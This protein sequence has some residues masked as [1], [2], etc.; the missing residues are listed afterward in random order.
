MEKL[1]MKQ[2]HLKTKMMDENWVKRQ[3]VAKILTGIL[4]ISVGVIIFMKQMGYAMPHWVLSWKTLLIAIGV[5]HLIKH[6]FKGI[7]GYVLIVIGTIF[8]LNDLLTIG[9]SPQFILPIAL[10][11][12]GIMIISKSFFSSKKKIEFIEKQMATFEIDEDDFTQVDSYFGGV[13]KNIVSKNFKGA[14][15]TSIFSG[16]EINLMQA[17]FENKATIDMNCIFGGITLIVPP[18]WKIVSQLTSAFGGIEDKRQ[19]DT[20]Q[21]GSSQKV[22]Y[23]KGKCVFGGVEIDSY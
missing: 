15:I 21:D 12:L 5:T 14:S 19:L 3:R 4:V 22:L 13:S 1:K 16:A 9:I 6:N 23:L 18:D 11:G 17:S 10:V 20:L 2:S 8:I 7:A